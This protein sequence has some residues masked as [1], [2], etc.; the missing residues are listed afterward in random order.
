MNEALIDEIADFLCLAD[1]SHWATVDH[2]TLAAL[3]LRIDFDIEDL[4]ETGGRDTIFALPA[5]P[6][7][8]N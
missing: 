7:P 8:N 5:I 2:H 1:S 3:S 6:L 4:L